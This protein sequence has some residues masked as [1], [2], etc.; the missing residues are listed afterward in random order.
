MSF[1][2]LALKQ[3]TRASASGLRCASAQ[4]VQRS[5][6]RMLKNGLHSASL[7][8]A[9]RS[10]VAKQTIALLSRQQVRTMFI[11][12][13]QTPNDD[14]LKFIPGVPVMETGTAEFLDVRESMKSPLAKQL[15]QIDGVAG[16]FFGP[17]FVTISKSSSSEWQL[18]KPD[19]YAAIM[20]HFSSGQPIVYNEADLAASDT[21]I[22]PD[23][24]EEVQMIKEL[25]DTRI[26]PA[27]Q[28]DGGDIEF[29]GF[30]DG[31]VKLKLKGSC[32]GCDSS[33]ITLKNGIE[34]MLMHYIPEVQ[35]VEQ[36]IDENEAVALQEFDKLEKK[37]GEK[38]A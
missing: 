5:S 26:R 28:E 21:T 15:F 37:L 12:T 8:F 32:R 20:D 18:M 38:Q 23:D 36:V 19:I 24:S 34:N 31:I 7:P 14:S 29:C 11:Q 13:E 4:Q 17:D 6:S 2:R 1:A 27:I 3:L 30:E 33:V 25:L 10:M 22:L 9:R 16:V 35:S